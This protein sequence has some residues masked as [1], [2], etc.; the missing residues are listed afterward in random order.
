MPPKRKADSENTETDTKKNKTSTPRLKKSKRVEWNRTWSEDK[1][2]GEWAQKCIERWCLLPPYDTRIPEKNWKKYY[3]ERTAL[4]AVNTVDSTASKPIVSEELDQDTFK[5][6]RRAS[7]NVAKVIYGAVSEEDSESTT[8]ARTIRGSLYYT[9]LWGNDEEGG[10]NNPRTVNSKTRLYS[11]F[12]LGTSLDIVYDY[13]YRCFRANERW[14]TLYVCARHSDECN[15][16]EPLK[17]IAVFKDD[18]GRQKPEEGTVKVINM[19]RSFPCLFS[20]HLNGSK[21]T[22]TTAKNLE[23]FEE[24]LFGGS[25]WLS[26]LKIFQLVAYAGTVGHYHEALGGSLLNKGGLEKFKLFKDEHDAKELGT[27]EAKILAD[28]EGKLGDKGDD[29][30]EGEICVPQR[31]LL[32]AKQTE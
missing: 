3:Q 6:L 12:G 30:E 7:A 25:G 17:S 26:P 14:S 22:G 9:G 23:E 27:A 21:I 11:P 5:I 32:L 15:T 1:L 24:T 13:H 18:R 20:V 2:E 16:K 4:D 28:A 8:I 19:V 29:K 31:L 10:G